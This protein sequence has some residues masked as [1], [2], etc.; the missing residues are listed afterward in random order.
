MCSVKF[1]APL[2]CVR[3]YYLSLNGHKLNPHY[4]SFQ[5]KSIHFPASQEIVIVFVGW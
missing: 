5:F 4:M 3:V 1:I 2:V